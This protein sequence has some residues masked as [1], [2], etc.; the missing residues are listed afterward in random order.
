MDSI[1]SVAAAYG[2]K[3]LESVVK[4]DKKAAP[5][6][7]AAAPTEQVEFSDASLSMQKLKEIIDE[8]PEVR[9]KAVE[10]IQ[11]KIKQNG[12]PI[13]S[14]LYKAMQKMFDLRVI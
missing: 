4:T 5:E 14:N 6:K 9:I 11:N 7:T 13:E 1:R 3:P 10:V 2:A 8:I 12:Y